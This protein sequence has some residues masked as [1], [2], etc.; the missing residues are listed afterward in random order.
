MDFL[1][2]RQAAR[3]LTIVKWHVNTTVPV[4][5][6]SMRERD[7]SYITPRI[8]ILLCR[9]NKLRRA[10]KTEQADH[11]ALK[12]NRLIAHNKSIAL[13][14]ASNTDTRQPRSLLKCTGNLGANKQTIS[15]LT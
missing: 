13:A 1:A 11:I 8:K 14:G 5:A 15:K 10:G 2:I 12:V 6:I 9:R 3:Y 4:C 7:P